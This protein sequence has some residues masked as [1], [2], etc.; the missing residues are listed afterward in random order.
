MKKLKQNQEAALA[1]LVAGA[2]LWPALLWWQSQQR[3]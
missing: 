2:L 1:G 3:K